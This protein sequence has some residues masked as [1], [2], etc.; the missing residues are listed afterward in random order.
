MS[1][2]VVLYSFITFHCRR[3]RVKGGEDERE[4]GREWERIMEM[5][6]ERTERCRCI[7]TDGE[8]GR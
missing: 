2:C 1:N 7:H 3:C 4:G 6:R 8:G 5:M